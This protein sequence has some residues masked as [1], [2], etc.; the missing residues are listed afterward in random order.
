MKDPQWRPVNRSRAYELVVQQVEDQILAGALGVGDRLPGEQDLASLLGVSR[1]A[2]REA[3]RTLEAQGVV[4][5]G[6]GV[7]PDGGTFVADMP[8]EALT[9]ILRVHVALANFPIPDVI[10]ARVMLERFSASLAA[11]QADAQDLARMRDLLHR[12]DAPDIGQDEFNELDTRL[13]VD[14]AEAGRN[15]LVADMTTAIR[16]AM[17]A[18][19]LRAYR[20]LT[21]WDD[22]VARLRRQ[23]REVYEAIAS[24][25]P[26]R[27]AD[28]VERHIRDAYGRLWRNGAPSVVARPA[29]QP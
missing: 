25:D 15:R 3:M 5:S 1:G 24:R 27:S 19:I 22:L 21:T 6:V 16:A 20:E 7:G 11:Q 13:H 9:R 29:R 10:E 23:H 26:A 2:V 14:I 17:E 18:P 4:R 12:M 28:T 8:S